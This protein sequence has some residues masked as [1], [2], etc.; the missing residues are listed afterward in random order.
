MR[1]TKAKAIRRKVYGEDSHK[2]RKYENIEGGETRFNT[3]LRAEYLSEK[4]N[5][6]EDK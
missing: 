6:K 2:T 1:G 4:K 3:G 5:S